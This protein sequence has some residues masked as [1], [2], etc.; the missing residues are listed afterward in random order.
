M[1]VL[2]LLLVRGRIVGGGT[3]LRNISSHLLYLGVPRT[4]DKYTE[5][6]EG[7]LNSIRTCI[8]FSCAEGGKT[9]PK[10]SPVIFC[11]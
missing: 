11:I 10:K 9:T 5:R 2:V 3:P 4:H 7:T 8:F 1:I 6:M